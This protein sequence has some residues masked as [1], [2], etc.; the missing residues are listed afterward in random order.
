MHPFEEEALEL[1]RDSAR[2]EK[3]VILASAPTGHARPIALG[4]SPDGRAGAVAYLRLGANGEAQIECVMAARQAADWIL[5]GSSGARWPANP[6]DEIEPRQSPLTLLESRADEPEAYMSIEENSEIVAL[7][8]YS[9]APV[10]I[11][12]AGGVEVSRATV[13]SGA[14]AVASNVKRNESVEVYEQA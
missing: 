13:S 6:F 8:G 4:I 3:E 9:R 12:K 7:I 14:Y 2:F 11:V 10:V 5:L 1:L